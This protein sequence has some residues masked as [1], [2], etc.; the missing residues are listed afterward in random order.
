MRERERSKQAR[1][2]ASNREQ[3]RASES[4]RERAIRRAISRLLY[5]TS[6]ILA[7]GT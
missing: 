2:E 4:K 5:L 1:K 3:V 6:R 7:N